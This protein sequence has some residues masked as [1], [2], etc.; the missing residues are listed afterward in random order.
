VQSLED[1]VMLVLDVRT[2]IP[3]AASPIFSC[4]F[5]VSFWDY[6][7]SVY[8]MLQDASCDVDGVLTTLVCTVINIHIG[9]SLLTD[10]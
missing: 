1:S 5:G 2:G 8:T 9:D 10:C 3:H 4:P 7:K 6:S